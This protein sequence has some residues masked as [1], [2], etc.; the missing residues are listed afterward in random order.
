MRRQV[1]AGDGRL[2]EAPSLTWTSIPKCLTAP[3]TDYGHLQPEPCFMTKENQL[4]DTFDVPVGVMLVDLTGSSKSEIY[5][6]L[7]DAI[8]FLREEA[9]Y[10]DEP[11]QKG[12]PRD[13]RRAL[14]NRFQRRHGGCARAPAFLPRTR[15]TA[16]PILLRL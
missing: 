6:V 7:A 13:V 1:C 9:Q 12:N 2:A 16:S 8:T 10:K 4:F 5:A 14:R 11:S 3:V 15:G